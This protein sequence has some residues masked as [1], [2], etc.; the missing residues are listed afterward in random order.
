MKTKIARALL[1]LA[2]TFI[3]R[4]VQAGPTPSPQVEPASGLAGV[5]SEGP[6]GGGPTRQGVSDSRPVVNTVFVVRKGETE[7]TSFTTDDQGR[8]H[9]FLSPGHYSVTKSGQRRHRPANY[10]P[11]EV[12]VIA[13]NVMKVQWECD[14]GMQ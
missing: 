8:F 5:I 3:S 14:T 1:L 11:F 6:I 7:V 10:G 13:G 9:I 2:L 4:F 12:E